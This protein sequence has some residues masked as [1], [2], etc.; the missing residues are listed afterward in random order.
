MV[1]NGGAAI[2]LHSCQVDCRVDSGV[3]CWS[4]PAMGWIH[5]NADGAVNPSTQ[6]ATSGGVLCDHDGCWKFGFAR[7][8]AIC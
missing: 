7:S 8:I 2:G 1:F 5:A 4:P 3:L 6:R